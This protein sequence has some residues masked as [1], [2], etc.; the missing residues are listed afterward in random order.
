MGV[1]ATK[2]AAHYAHDHRELATPL[3]D[4]IKVLGLEAKNR[5]PRTEVGIDAFV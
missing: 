5:A 4:G 1:D 3:A 2:D